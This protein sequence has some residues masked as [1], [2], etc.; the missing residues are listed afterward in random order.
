MVKML[1]SDS[2]AFMIRGVIAI[3]IGLAALLFPGPTLAG[4]LG[5]FAAYAVIDGAFAIWGGVMGTGN[6]HLLLVLGGIAA[7][8][9]GL[10]TVISPGTTALVL[11]L[12]IGIMCIARG[13][14]EIGAAY[15][16]RKVVRNAAL[17]GL[18]GVVSIIFGL[19]LVVLPGDGVLTLLWL[20]GIYAI[21][22]GVMYLAIG[23][24]GRTV[25][26]ALAM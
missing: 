6:H 22:A 21:F 11:V 15:T 23:F 9:V 2:G 17:V 10:L 13:A 4:L 18:L 14:A 24:R 20:I 7:I 25:A 16:L 8:A 26:K 12:W 19:Y 1:A 3:L 5:V